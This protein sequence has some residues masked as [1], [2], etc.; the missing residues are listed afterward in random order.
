VLLNLCLLGVP[1]AVLLLA[2]LH[3][4]NDVRQV[5][6]EGLVHV[7]YP[8]GDLLLLCIDDARNVAPVPECLALPIQ[9]RVAHHDIQSKLRQE[10]LRD[11]VVHVEYHV[12]DLAQRVERQDPLLESAHRHVV[13]QFEQ[14]HVIVQPDHD[15]VF[16]LPQVHRLDQVGVVETQEIERALQLHRAR[17]LLGLA[18]LDEV[19][20][21]DCVHTVVLAQHALPQPAHEGALLVLVLQV[22]L[23]ARVVVDLH[24]LGDQIRGRDPASAVELLVAALLL[25]LREHVVALRVQAQVVAVHNELD[26]LFIQEVERGDLRGVALGLVH[27]LDVTEQR[28][29]LCVGEHGLRL[30]LGHVLVVVDAHGQVP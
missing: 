18:A 22:G 4:R 16:G 9:R 1:L 13:R 17:P 19:L 26:A 3:A 23:P 15:L 11:A 30:Q 10:C 14:A 21:H 29:A 25:V 28:V 7:G 24:E 27:P 2:S 12:V 6:L 8:V 20:E 5:Q